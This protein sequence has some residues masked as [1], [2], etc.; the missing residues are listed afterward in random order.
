MREHHQSE[1]LKESFYASGSLQSHGFEVGLVLQNDVAAFSN[2]NQL[3]KVIQAK[4]TQVT[5]GQIC[6]MVNSGWPSLKF[7]LMLK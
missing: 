2:S 6:C 3:L 7:M 1:D 5:T 4:P